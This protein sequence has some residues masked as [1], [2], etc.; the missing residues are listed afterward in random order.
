[1]D[2]QVKINEIFKSIQGETTFQGLPSIFIRITG[3]NLRCNWCDTKYA[4]YD[5]VDYSVDEILKIVEKYHCKYIVI[6]GGEPLIQKETPVLVEHL[7][8]GGYKVLVETNGSMDISVLHPDTF[9]IVDIKCPGSGMTE[10]MLWQNIG[11][12]SPHDEVKFVVADYNDYHWIKSI[13]TSFKL[14]DICTVLI[15][16]AYGLLDP[17]ILAEWIINDNLPVRLQLQIHKYIWGPD[18]RGI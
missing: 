4:Y 8:K 6:T 9:K 10:K 2:L 17:I 18:A 1:M 15:S 3:C 12:L 13:I 16:P 7:I 5:G 14:P 11:Y